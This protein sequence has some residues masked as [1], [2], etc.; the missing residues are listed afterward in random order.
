MLRQLCTK[1]P[2]LTADNTDNTDQEKPKPLQH[3]GTEVAEKSKIYRGFARMSADQKQNSNCSFWCSDH[4]IT[5]FPSVSSVLSVV[6]VG[7]LCKAVREQP[8]TGDGK[9]TAYTFRRK[10][11]SAQNQPVHSDPCL[12]RANY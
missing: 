9:L 2:N 11:F 10:T 8:Q 1:A 3:G 6:R 5:R 4:R 12:G 7:F